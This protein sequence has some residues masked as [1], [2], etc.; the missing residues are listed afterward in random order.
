M[1]GNKGERKENEWKISVRVTEPERL[2]TLGN[3]QGVV[4]GRWVEGWSNW[5]MGT[6]GGT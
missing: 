6:E 3:E 1:K 2:L 5:V 4:K